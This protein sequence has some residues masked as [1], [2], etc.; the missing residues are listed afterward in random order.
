VNSGPLCL[1]T[2][3]GGTLGNEFC[4]RYSTRFNIVAVWS[5]RPP[6]ISSQEQYAFDPLDPTVQPTDNPGSVFTIRA[7]VSKTAATQRVVDRVVD[8]FG[9]ID[10]IVHAAGFRHWAPMFERKSLLNSVDRHF[11]VNVR[12]PLALTIQVAQR[13]WLHQ[14]AL[15]NRENNR[16]VVFVSSTAGLRVYAGYGQSVYSASKAALNLLGQHIA[17]ELDPMGVRANILAPGSFPGMIPTFR[18]A[19]AV[20]QLAQGT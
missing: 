12:A 9:R 19:D 15:E 16:N 6:L 18:V 1:L 10:I 4:R 5:R 8:Q 3:S 11:Q 7:D 17:S 14:S 13:F 2:G 20:V